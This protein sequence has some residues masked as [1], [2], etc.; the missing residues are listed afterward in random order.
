ML[1]S[2]RSAADVTPGLRVKTASTQSCHVT[3]GRPELVLLGPDLGV[4]D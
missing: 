1:L 2:K 4:R 3:E